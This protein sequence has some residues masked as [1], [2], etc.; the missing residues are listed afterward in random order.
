MPKGTSVGVEDV[1]KA[2]GIPTHTF[3]KPGNFNRLKVALRT[4]GRGII[5]EGPSGIGKSTAIAK[6]IEDLQINSEIRKLSARNPA[7][8]ETIKNI[9]KTP[10]TGTI[11]IDDFHKLDD[12]VKIQISDL[13]KFTADTEDPTKKLVLIGINEAGRRLIESSGDLGNR[14]EVIRFEVEPRNKIEEL[15]SAGEQ[16]LNVNIAS[17]E[18]IKSKASGSFYIAQLLCSEACIEAGVL[19]RQNTPTVVNTSY[20]AIQ[21]RVVEKQRSRFGDQVKLFARGKKFRPGGRAPYLHILRWLS[22]SEAWNISIPE[23]IRQH[24]NERASVGTVYDRG[25]LASLCET[26]GIPEIL[27][28]DPDTGILSVEDPMLV[29]YLKAI[30]WS[31]FVSE[32]GFTNVEHDQAYDVALSFAGED[33]EYAEH[34]RDALEDFGHTVFYDQSEQHRIIGNDVETILRPIYESNSRFV[35]AILGASY[36]R[37]RW[38]FFENSVYEE[39]YPLGEVIPIWS[40]KTSASATDP[41]ASIGSLAYDPLEDLR[42]KAIEH[43]DTISR[44]IAED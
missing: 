12:D 34:L 27:H 25:F 24:P 35:V 1:F 22:E 3:V 19:D 36:G 23:E 6:A 15:I 13:L 44:R 5:L 30:D 37:K 7:D 41:V 21:R 32:V 38:T 11:I 8:V 39:R 40:A 16:A 43:A 4:P 2:S 18:N 14:I 10:G 42:A 20:S 26:E 9:P 17:S 29:Y 33:R 28:F 31:N